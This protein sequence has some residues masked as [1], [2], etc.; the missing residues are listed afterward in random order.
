KA[1]PS[2]L[3]HFRALARLAAAGLLE[4]HSVPP[5]GAHAA[6][7]AV[8]LPPKAPLMRTFAALCLLVF[9]SPLTA[10]DFSPWQGAKWIWDE[11]DANTVAQNNEPRY[12]RL[13]FTITGKVSKAEL[14]VTVDNHYV[15][16]V[17]GVKVGED[18]EWNSVEKYDVAKLLVPGKNVLAIKAT[19]Q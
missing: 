16:Y 6:R 14:W 18:A 11:A 2:A 1:K 13:P 15:A 19:N 3:P 8:S 4:S 9:A 17:N 5:P 10:Q 12:L 7:L